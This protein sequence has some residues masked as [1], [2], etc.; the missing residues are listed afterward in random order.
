MACQIKLELCNFSMF[1]EMSFR[2]FLINGADHDHQEIRDFDRVEQKRHG[3]ACKFNYDPVQ[4]LMTR[5]YTTLRTPVLGPNFSIR[6]SPQYQFK[7]KSK[8][9]G[10]VKRIARLSPLIST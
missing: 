1:H 3:E 4:F 8:S 9:S 10:R 2:L 6:C 7:K 5:T